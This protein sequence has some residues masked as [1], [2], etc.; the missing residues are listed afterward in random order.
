M[1][2]V[3]ASSAAVRL[4]DTPEAEDSGVGQS[5]CVEM[6]L[7]FRGGAINCGAFYTVSNSSSKHATTSFFFFF[8]IQRFI[9]RVCCHLFI[10]AIGS[11]LQV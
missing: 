2:H 6:E 9:Y 10:V 7:R 4:T 1:I 5:D 8:T 3:G 11:A